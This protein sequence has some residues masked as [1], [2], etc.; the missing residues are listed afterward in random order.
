[1]RFHIDNPN[2]STGCFVP[3]SRFRRWRRRT[4][5]A[6]ISF[7]WRFRYLETVKKSSLSMWNLR[8]VANTLSRLRSIPFSF[9][10]VVVGV[11]VKF[12]HAILRPPSL[13]RFK[14]YWNGS[15]RRW[16]SYKGKKLEY[17]DVKYMKVTRKLMPKYLLCRRV[18]TK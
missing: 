2:S 7:K 3:R 9:G 10:L 16:L 17:L 18:E 1:M 8:S 14:R 12:T 5:R 11:D 4:Q 13:Q 15:Q 6:T